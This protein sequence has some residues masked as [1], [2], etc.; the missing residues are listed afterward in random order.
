MVKLMNKELKEFK[1]NWIEKDNDW[2]I[3]SVNIEGKNYGAYH[4]NKDFMMDKMLKEYIEKD[5]KGKDEIKNNFS[6]ERINLNKDTTINPKITLKLDT[7]QVIEDLEESI[8]RNV[9]VVM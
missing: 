1:I 9:K 8:K 2:I 4:Y 6:G 3:A 7:E 5:L